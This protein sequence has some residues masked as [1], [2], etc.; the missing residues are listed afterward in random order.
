M[1]DVQPKAYV[2]AGQAYRELRARGVTISRG[3][4]YA[5]RADSRIDTVSLPGTQRP[6]VRRA[7]LDQLAPI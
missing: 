4:C 7:A 2:S 5:M 1:S 3:L 6:F